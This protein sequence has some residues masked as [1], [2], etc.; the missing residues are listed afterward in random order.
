MY[1]AKYVPKSKMGPSFIVKAYTWLTYYKKGS[2]KKK[3]SAVADMLKPANHGGLIQHR[4]LQ[5]LSWQKLSPMGL[6]QL[7][8]KHP[9]MQ[10]H[11]PPPPSI[12]PKPFCW[13]CHEPASW[14][15]WEW[16]Q[17][18]PSIASCTTAFH[19]RIW[20]SVMSS[21]LVCFIWASTQQRRVSMELP[22]CTPSL[23]YD[24]QLPYFPHRAF[25]NRIP[26]CGT[27]K[28]SKSAFTSSKI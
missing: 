12:Q 9:L 27:R 8:L 14:N 11:E 16:S 6:A 17:K 25:K 15:N 24:E 1:L 20:T 23:K 7:H 18:P 22:T 21:S 26:P 3:R 10:Q 13:I 28:T 2:N 5:K 19:S 4:I